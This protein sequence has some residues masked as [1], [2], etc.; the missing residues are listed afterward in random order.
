MLKHEHYNEIVVSRD[1]LI[2]QLSDS[3]CWDNL[4]QLLMYGKEHLD[5]ERLITL[6]ALKCE[7]LGSLMYS[8]G[9]DNH[10]KPP[11]ETYLHE[12]FESEYADVDELTERVRDI[13]RNNLIRFNLSPDDANLLY[14]KLLFV[15]YTCVPCIADA[16]EIWWAGTYRHFI[17]YA[18]DYDSF[19]YPRTES[20]KLYGIVD[21]NTPELSKWDDKR[22]Y[23]LEH[24]PESLR[25]IIIEKDE[26]SGFRD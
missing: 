12:L 17:E 23:V 1:E 3:S 24:I 8:D 14:R 26:I 4:L 21:Y 6:T 20:D 2:Y 5:F 9:L 22:G 18:I 16:T 25:S 19:S 7:F 11:I 10:V 13:Q 15:I